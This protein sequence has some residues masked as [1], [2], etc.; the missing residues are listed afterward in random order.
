[1]ISSTM[2]SAKYSCSGSPLMFSNGSTAIEG[3]PGKASPGSPSRWAVAKAETRGKGRRGK[4]PVGPGKARPVTANRFGE[5]REVM[6]GR[7]LHTGRPAADD[8]LVDADGLSEPPAAE[9]AGLQDEAELAR[10]VRDRGHAAPP[11]PD[12][13][14]GS[15]LAGGAATPR[16]PTQLL[17]PNASAKVHSG[18]RRRTA[19]PVEEASD[20]RPDRHHC[21]A[22]CF[23]LR[24]PP[25]RSAATFCD[26]RPPRQT[27]ARRDGRLSTLRGQTP[28]DTTAGS[29]CTHESKVVSRRKCSGTGGLR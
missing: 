19:R 25:C 21:P 12:V 26:E 14:A 3:G 24:E 29:G 15:P 23:V 11:L 9:I 6:V 10:E 7:R 5:Q 16:T 28:L 27:R 18:G 8:G 22:L 2:P 1:M 20:V 4:L 17:A 13:R